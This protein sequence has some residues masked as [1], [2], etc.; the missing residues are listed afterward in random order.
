MPESELETAILTNLQAL[1]LSVKEHHIKP[2]CMKE[3]VSVTLFKKLKKTEELIDKRKNDTFTLYGM[4][5]AGKVSEESFI[6]KMAD[7]ESE[8]V[9]LEEQAKQQEMEYKKAIQ[10]Q[11]PLAPTDAEQIQ[12]HMPFHQLTKEVIDEFIEAVYIE[13]GGNIS[14]KWRFSDP[15]LLDKG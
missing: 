1:A 7:L 11:K 6:K 14:I 3:S 5:K 15:F 8:L 10:E 2:K 13:I 12:K 4:F 9:E